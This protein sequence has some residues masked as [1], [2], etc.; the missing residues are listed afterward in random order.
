MDNKSSPRYK[1]NDDGNNLIY[2][3]PYI[4]LQMRKC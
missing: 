4:E 3:A 1:N 2:K